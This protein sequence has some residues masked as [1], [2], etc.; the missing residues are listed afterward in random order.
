[1]AMTDRAER[2]FDRITELDPGYVEDALAF[3]P[4]DRTVP[5]RRW[6]GIA[7]AVLLAA[8][9]GQLMPRMGI[10]SKSE[11]PADAA[12][13]AC[14]P[15]SPETS[16][17]ESL[18]DSVTGTEEGTQNGSLRGACAPG[19]EIYLSPGEIATVLTPEE[20]AAL[21]YPAELTDIAKGGPLIWLTWENEQYTLCEHP[22][23]IGLYEY[24]T[25]LYVISDGEQCWAAAVLSP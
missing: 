4:N 25:H 1:M 2:L 5:W 12:S 15:E 8:S 11:A 19:V 16:G 6:G 23:G 18:Y 14:G 22:T 20:A 7:A 3:V 17:I 13:T 21:G 9:V 10:S 24:D